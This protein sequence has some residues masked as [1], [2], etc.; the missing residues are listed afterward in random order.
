[1]RLRTWSSAVVLALVSVLVPGVAAQ[2]APARAAGPQPLVRLASGREF[3]VVAAG[4]EWAVNGV[5]E[6]SQWYGEVA[7][8]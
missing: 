1:M 2:A 3:D 6:L 4:H 8:T 7:E 5:P